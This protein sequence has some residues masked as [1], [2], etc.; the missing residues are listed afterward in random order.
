MPY[1]FPGCYPCPFCESLAGRLSHVPLMDNDYAVAEISDCERTV[2]G[3]AVLVWPKQ[4]LERIAQLSDRQ[5]RDIIEL[6]YRTAS[7]VLQALQPQGFH[8][9]CSAGRLVGQSE[10]HMHFQI[11]PRY[12]NRPYSFAAAQDLPSI[13][14]AHR[15]QLAAQ[16]LPYLKIDTTEQVVYHSLGLSTNKPSSALQ[17]VSQHP[18]LTVH[19]TA[20][21]T[22]LCHPQNRGYGSLV[23]LS[24]SQAACFL[25]LPAQQRTELAVLIRD[26]AQLVETTLNPDGLSIWWDTGAAA[27]QPGS[28]FIAEIV[29]RFKAIPYQHQHRTSISFG[30]GKELSDMAE[31]YRNNMTCPEQRVDIFAP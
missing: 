16:V 29:P 26:L 30:Y 15:A 14:L 10:A 25:L 1:D 18:D 8:I 20:H 11:Q 13:P 2:A 12:L 28:E 5:V 19:E 27:N 4:H 3:G 23:V 22:A 9:F 7:A 31:V 21:F 17:L 6:V 24:K